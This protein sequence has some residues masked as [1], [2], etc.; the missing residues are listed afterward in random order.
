MASRV[1]PFLLSAVLCPLVF[2][3]CKMTGGGS[4]RDVSYDPAKLKT[5]AGHGMER[6]DYPFDESGAYR[7]DWVKANA[8]GRDG[9]A[10]KTAESLATNVAPEATETSSAPTSYPTYAEAAAARSG[11][12]PAVAPGESVGPTGAVVLAEAGNPS[13]ESGVTVP[14]AARYHKVSSGDTLFGLASRYQT[15]VDD[16]K[17]INGLSGDSIRVGQSL[18]LP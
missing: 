14:A 4:Y 1:L 11:A 8:R 6:K 12:I 13:T 7:K 9:S 16:L 5:P 18:R 2:T 10:S 15:S 3:Q 17:R